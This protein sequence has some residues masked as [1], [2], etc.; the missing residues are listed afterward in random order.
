M[1]R[2]PVPVRGAIAT[3]HRLATRAGE[4]AFQAGGNALDAALAAA[5]VLSVVYPHNTG[6]GGDL[7]AL[8]HAPD[9]TMHGINATGWAAGGGSREALVARHGAA[10]PVR[11]IDTVTVPGALRGWAAIESLGARLS[12]SQRLAS[13]RTAAREGVPVAASLAL[14]LASEWTAILDD[15][16][17][18]VFGRSGRALQRGE[19]LVQSALA[20]TLDV[21]V[22]EGTGA[23][24]DDRL[25]AGLAQR[26]AERGSALRHEDFAEFQADDADPIRLD[27]RDS[28]IWTLGPNTQGFALLRA[29]AALELAGADPDPATIAALFRDGN[30]LRDTELGDPH[31]VPIDLDRLIWGSIDETEPEIVGDPRLARGDTIGIAAADADG[32]SVSLVQSLFHLFG[33]GI[34]DVESG[35]LFQNRGSSFALQAE[36]PNAYGPRTRPAHTLMPVIVTDGA[37]RMR[38]VQASMGGKA[39]AQVHTQL[40]LRLDAGATAAEA[41]RA[42]RWTVGAYAP[43]DRSDS[44]YAEADV[45]D[46]TIAQVLAAGFPVVT[47]PPLT[48]MLGHANVV[49]A[50]AGGF[51]AAADPRSDGAAST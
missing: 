24:Y 34:Y 38:F 47:V 41:V 48:E 36:S 17:R 3:P 25:G 22:A 26:L 14:C 45:P 5:A 8:V 21:L 30:T 28:Q 15:G 27:W 39:Q 31:R 9:G 49:R 10:L 44:V 2:A 19:I 40:L 37:G 50:M 1:G 43:G 20:D 35:V 51:D 7:V 6:I 13:A 33:S 18:R 23:F 12:R 46:A 16:F 42:P 4:E 11:G 29:A 32:W